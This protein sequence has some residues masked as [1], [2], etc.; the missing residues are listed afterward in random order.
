MVNI[1]QVKVRYFNLAFGLAVE[2]RC[3]ESLAP[4]GNTEKTCQK[5]VQIYC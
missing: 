4:Y 2:W 1:L 3:V 5:M